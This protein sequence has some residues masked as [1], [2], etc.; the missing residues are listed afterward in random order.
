MAYEYTG[1]SVSGT[2]LWAYMK[3]IIAAC[4]ERDIKVIAVVRPGFNS[5]RIMKP[6]SDDS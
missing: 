4:G 6:V 1:T 3:Q 5:Y 2:D